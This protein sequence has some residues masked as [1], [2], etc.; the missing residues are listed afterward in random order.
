[1]TLA[2]YWQASPVCFP[3]HH[4]PIRAA[5]CTLRIASYTVLLYYLTSFR[6]GVSL[7]YS[8][9]ARSQ[10]VTDCTSGCTFYTSASTM[11]FKII[12]RVASHD[13]TSSRPGD[14]WVNFEYCYICIASDVKRSTIRMKF[15][16]SRKTPAAERERLA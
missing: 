4:V 1:M 8:L 2:R 7:Q 11:T 5:S 6:D 15:L 14:L 16:I 12:I 3:L 10:Q 13:C 9:T